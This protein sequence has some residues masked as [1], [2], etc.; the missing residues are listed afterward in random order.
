[1]WSCRDIS[2]DWFCEITLSSKWYICAP[3]TWK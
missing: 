3:D 1:V 2:W